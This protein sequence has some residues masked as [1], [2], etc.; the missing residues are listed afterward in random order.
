MRSTYVTDPNV[1]CSFLLAIL[2]G[3]RPS[4]DTAAKCRG[5]YLFYEITRSRLF[6]Q[7]VPHNSISAYTKVPM[8]LQSSRPLRRRAVGRHT[9]PRLRYPSGVCHVRHLPTSFF[10]SVIIGIFIFLRCTLGRRTSC[11]LGFVD[12]VKDQEMACP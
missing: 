11:G 7:D 6:F 10:S 12:A 4:R 8:M 1:Q 9:Q 3:K 5:K 2:N